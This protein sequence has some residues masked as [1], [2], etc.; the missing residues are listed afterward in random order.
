MAMPGTDRLPPVFYHPSLLVVVDDSRS[1]C[2]SIKF[3]MPIDQ[4]IV[5]FDDPRKAIAWLRT[6]TALCQR[7]E[8]EISVRYDD[9][10]LSMERRVVEMDLAW[11]HRQTG[12]ADRFLHPAVVA[13]D[14]SMPEMSG[15]EFC[16]EIAD[17]P[18]RRVLLTGTADESVAVGGFNGG[19]IDRYIKKGDPDALDKLASC[20]AELQESYFRTLSGTVREILSR[21]S[22]PFLSEPATSG[23][24]A[25]LMARYGFVEYCLYPNP[26]GFLLLTARGEATLM[27]IETEASLLAHCEAAAMFDA[28]DSLVHALQDL[29]VV[30][31]FW[32]GNGMYVPVCYDWEPYCLPASTYAGRDTYYYALFSLPSGSLPPDVYDFQRFM[33]DR[34]PMHPVGSV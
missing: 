33:I 13:V 19:M 3:G 6:R 4:P 20:V 21:H 24:L 16:G 32:P 25:H 17:L 2:D 7:N 14:F 18:C 1:Y 5:T 22:F 15:L 34:D 11:I 27:V 28:P 31:F 30:P 23:V 29:Q 12:R 9:A 8:P 26:G 10:S